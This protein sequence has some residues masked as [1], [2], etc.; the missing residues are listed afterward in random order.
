MK[1]FFKKIHSYSH[2]MKYAQHFSCTPFSF[3]LFFSL[4]KTNFRTTSKKSLTCK[5]SRINI[6]TYF[7]YS[8]MRKNKNGDARLYIEKISQQTGNLFVSFPKYPDTFTKCDRIRNRKHIQYFLLWLSIV[9]TKW[10]SLYLIENSQ[11]GP[12][13]ITPDPR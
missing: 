10:I 9:Q 6:L 3:L 2:R 7:W 12:Q 4:N 1:K 5:I 11:T 13:N 8:S